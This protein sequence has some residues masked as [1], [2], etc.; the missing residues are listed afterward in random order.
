MGRDFLKPLIKMDKI[1][2][3]F[4]KV[5][6]VLLL[7]V[8][9]ILVTLQCFELVWELVKVVSVKAQEGV[10][11]YVPNQ[12]RNV[13]VLFFNILLTLEVM[14]TVRAIHKKHHIKLRVILIVCLIAVSRKILM[15]ET[16]HPEPLTEFA[17]AALIIALALGYFLVSKSGAIEDEKTNASE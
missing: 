9:M 4:D 11:N 3:K 13:V 6:T 2:V 5:V 12:G 15:L 16:Q 10:M 7:A 1:N 17:V 8:A 14:E